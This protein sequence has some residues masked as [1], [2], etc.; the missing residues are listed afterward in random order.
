MR[1]FIFKGFYYPV[2]GGAVG[3]CNSRT[4]CVIDKRLGGWGN[5]DKWWS[6]SYGIHCKIFNTDKPYFKFVIDKIVNHPEMKIVKKYFNDDGYTVSRAGSNGFLYC[7]E[8]KQG[9]HIGDI[10]DAYYIT[11]LTSLGTYSEDSKQICHGWDAEE[12]KAY[13]WSHRAKVGFGMGDMIF[14]ENFG[15][16]TT[17]YIKHGKMKIF[18]VDAAMKSALKFAE[19]VA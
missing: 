14:E 1:R 5:A 12:R 17:P 7:V 10:R 19:S 16:E 8:D 9:N 3:W 15:D 6:F 11:N 4:K 2:L 13:G 18:T